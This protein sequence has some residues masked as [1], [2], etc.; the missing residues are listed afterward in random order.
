MNTKRLFIG[1]GFLWFF[2]ISLFFLTLYL[3]L[4]T[5]P[6]KPFFLDERAIIGVAV[7]HKNK[8]YTLNLEQ[9]LFLIRLLNKSVDY[10]KPASY[11]SSGFEKMI[12]YLPSDQNKELHPIG[13]VE[14]ELVYEAPWTKKK[15]MVE[16]SGGRLKEVLSQIYGP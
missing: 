2:L 8:L 14:N 7:S 13:F 12:F 1:T 9:Q 3:N 5:P 10:E 4:K 16:K 15:W 11:L 6:E